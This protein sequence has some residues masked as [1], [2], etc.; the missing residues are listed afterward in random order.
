MLL[1]LF[2]LS[3]LVWQLFLASLSM[4]IFPYVFLKEDFFLLTFFQVV[5]E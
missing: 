2:Y 5:D 3:I 4:S 1:I